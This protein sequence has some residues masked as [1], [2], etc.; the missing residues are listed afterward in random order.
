MV[1]ADYIGLGAEAGPHPY[2]VGAPEARSV[3]DAVRAARQLGEVD[4]SGTTVVWGHSQGGG[5]AL[6]TGIVAR[7]Y[8]PDVPLAGVAALAPASDVV[9][10]AQELRSNPAGQLFA[11][12]VVQGYSGAYPDVRFDDYVRPAARTVARAAARRCLSEPAILLS[13]GA[14]LPGEN[15]FRRDLAT[16]ALGRRLAENVPAR[17]SEVPTLLAQG[18][19]DGLVLPGVQRAFVRRLCAA[20]QAVDYRAYAG[21]DHVALVADDS[22]LTPELLA[23]TDD[24]VAGRPA[25]GCTAREG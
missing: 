9:A 14:V 21:R 12:Y 6:W 7:A 25:T 22:P 4:L 10:L 24:R 5:A 19:D 11:A 3:L 13:I 1:A 18:L 17:P 23:W 8:A 20:G 15:L 2:L 16:G